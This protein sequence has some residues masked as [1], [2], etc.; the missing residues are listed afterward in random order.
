M[1]VTVKVDLCNS[2]EES[3]ICFRCQEKVHNGERHFHWG[4]QFE[5]EFVQ[6]SFHRAPTKKLV[7]LTVFQSYGYVDTF[8]I[9]AWTKINKVNRRGKVLN[10]ASASYLTLEQI[11][12]VYENPS[13]ELVDKLVNENMHVNTYWTDKA[14]EELKAKE[15]TIGKD[16][17]ARGARVLGLERNCSECGISEAEMVAKNPRYTLCR[18]VCV[19][20]YRKLYRKKEPTRENSH[21]I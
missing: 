12:E 2:D 13:K 1:P 19:V 4:I 5:K 14:L 9:E 7:G 21:Q 17:I 16:G 11:F 3:L 18:G 10:P 20:C 15:V 8:S 6:C